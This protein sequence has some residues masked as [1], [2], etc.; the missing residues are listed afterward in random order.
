M[1]HNNGKIV[2]FYNVYRKEII[3]ISNLSRN[4]DLMTILIDR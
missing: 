2:T 3:I 1:M 4:D